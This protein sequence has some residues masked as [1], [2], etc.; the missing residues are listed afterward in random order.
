MSYLKI[1]TRVSLFAI[2]LFVVLFNNSA[3]DHGSR[4]L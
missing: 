3:D 4:G 1:N 2:V